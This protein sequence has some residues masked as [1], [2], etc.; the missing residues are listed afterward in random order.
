MG[1]RCLAKSSQKSGYWR[2]SK[3]VGLSNTFSFNGCGFIFAWAFCASFWHTL[4]E[5]CEIE[6]LPKWCWQE[7]GSRFSRCKTAFNRE[8]F[9]QRSLGWSDFYSLSHS[10]F[11]N[12]KSVKSNRSSPGLQRRGPCGP[13]WENIFL[14]PSSSRRPE[15][16][17]L[18]GSRRLWDIL[19]HI[20]THYSDLFTAVFW[21]LMPLAG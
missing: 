5:M 14:W 4:S 10:K 9:L 8:V 19:W 12:S 6:L 2:Q 1:C 15:P 18:D 7:T 11:A 17:D 3:T 16:L 21:H 13:G 20:V